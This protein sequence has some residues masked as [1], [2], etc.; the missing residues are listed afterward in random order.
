MDARPWRPRRLSAPGSPWR[1]PLWARV[2]YGPI[3]Y[4]DSTT[5]PPR[6]RRTGRN[7]LDEIDPEILATLPKSSAFRCASGK[8]CSASR[9]RKST[10]T[11]EEGRRGWQRGMVV[12][13]SMRCSTRYSVATT[14]QAELAK[15]GVLFMPISEALAEASRSGE[16]ISRHRGAGPPT[17]FFAN[18]QPRRCVLRRLLR[19][20]GRRAV[21][22][23]RWS[24]RPISA[25]TSAIPASFERTLIIADKGSYV[26]YLGRLHG[27][28]ARREPAARR[29]WSSL[30]ALD[31][32][33]IKYSTIQNWYPGDAQRPRR[34]LTTSSPNA[35][36]C[37]GHEL[38]DFLDPARDRL[39]HYLEISEL[40]SWPRRPILAANSIRSQSPTG[41]PAGRFR[42]QRCCISART[43]RAASISKGIR[44]PAS[45]TIPIR[46]LVMPTANCQG[47]GR[48]LLPIATRCSSATDA[49]HTRCPISRRRMPPPCSSMRRTTSKDLR[50]HVVLLPAARALGGRR[51]GAGGERPSSRTC[52]SSC[53]WN[54]RS[55]L[56]S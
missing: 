39:G 29:P 1:E 54:S 22:P 3:D 13:R 51:G 45:R 24:S 55:R 53:R 48:Q 6:R 18:A 28:D 38:E 2:S 8:R 16:E 23:A 44:L 34:R 21:A 27:A 7:R 4:Q 40:Q 14:F 32:A 35:G 37:R 19:L 41:P 26:S 47:R 46:G 31:D 15:A 56:R 10:M 30:I 50:G 5:I 20:R 43:R 49:A 42:H 25:S 33:E 52:C 36:L 9:S 12:S 11:A 17:I